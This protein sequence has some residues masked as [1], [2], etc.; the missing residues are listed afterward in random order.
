MTS[1]IHWEKRPGCEFNLNNVTYKDWADP[2]PEPETRYSSDELHKRHEQTV[3][4]EY[5]LSETV[6]KYHHFR[7]GVVESY[8]VCRDELIK[9]VLTWNKDHD[10]EQQLIAVGGRFIRQ[11]DGSQRWGRS[12]LLIFKVKKAQHLEHSRNIYDFQA[13]LRKHPPYAYVSEHRIRV[14]INSYFRICCTNCRLTLET[15]HDTANC[16]LLRQDASS[17]P[18]VNTSQA[19]RDISWN[20]AIRIEDQQASMNNL[21]N[22]ILKIQMERAAAVAVRDQSSPLRISL[23]ATVAS[24]GVL[25]T[26]S[27]CEVDIEDE[28]DKALHS[29]GQSERSSSR[30]TGHHLNRSRITKRRAKHIID[31]EAIADELA[32]SKRLK[33]D[34][35]LP[36]YA[37]ST[38][39]SLPPS[40]PPPPSRDRQS[41]VFHPQS[42]PLIRASAVVPEMG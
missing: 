24:P 12:I 15:I 36:V 26:F 22:M 7:L 39:P 20:G 8:H 14:R 27:L 35:T 38:P 30:S 32:R 31:E 40:S 1:Y 4:P 17:L 2:M 33:L 41:P 23:H 6:F 16:P 13:E 29:A 34:I 10:T 19:S 28:V 18:V 42:S 5:G 25:G 21:Q 37:T 3:D 9:S 11:D